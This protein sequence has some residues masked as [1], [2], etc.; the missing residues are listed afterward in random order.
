[1]VRTLPSHSETR[2]ELPRILAIA[3]AIAVHAFA[4]L[5][6]LI[7]LSTPMLQKW[8]E[9][10]NPDVI[11]IEP[12]KKIIEKPVEIE[13]VKPV[14]AKPVPARTQRAVVP[15]T[16]P[17]VIV[18]GGPVAATATSTDTQTA[19]EMGPAS[20]GPVAVSTL[21]YVNAPPPVYPREAARTGAQGTVVLKILVDVDG[22]PLQVVV[23]E[24]SGNRWLDRAAREHVLKRWRFQPAMRDGQSVQAYGLVPI[25]FTM[26]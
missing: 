20:T 23:Q 8:V 21:A 11:F 17:A 1:M 15:D 10:V 25:N 13:A 3:A 24:S 7:P 9:P 16:E 6:L 22:T 2:P 18:E 12:E 26:Q 14:T 5:L 19:T 4:F